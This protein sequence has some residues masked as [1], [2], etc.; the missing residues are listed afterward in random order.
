MKKRTRWIV[1]GII[2]MILVG[3]YLYASYFFSN[4]LIARDMRSLAEDLAQTDRGSYTDSGLPEPENVSINNGEITLKGWFFDNEADGDCGVLLLHGYGGTRNGVLQYAPLFWERGCDLLAYDA[5]GHGDSSDAY[6]TY[7]YYEKEDGK[8]AL[9]W[10]AAKTGL[11]HSQIGLAGVSYGA[12]TVLQMLPLVDDVAFVLAD[13]PYQDLRTIVEH[14]S[15][16][17]FGSLVKPFVPSAFILAELRADFDADAVSPINGITETD[18]PVFLTHSLQD[19]FTPVTNSE[20]I[21]AKSNPAITE[22]L[23][24]DWGASHAAS[25]IVDYDLYKQ[26]VTE[27]LATYTPDFGLSG[28]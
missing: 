12:A 27:F 7:G 17:Q 16:A 13:S 21:F 23:L 26:N 1:L 2:L 10:F 15:T 25:I 11:P 24:T 8:A 3:M 6:H 14:Q 9:D 20:A 28:E 5:R 19:E 22:F 4:Q 18:V